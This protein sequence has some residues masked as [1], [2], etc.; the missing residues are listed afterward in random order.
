MHEQ[1]TSTSKEHKNWK[2]YDRVALGAEEGEITINVSNLVGNSSVLEMKNTKYNVQNAHY[3]ARE[4]VPQ[5]TLETLNND[6]WVRKFKNVF[7]KIDVQGYELSVIRKLASAEYNIIGF[8]IKLSLI[9]LYENQE[10]YLEIAGF[11]KSMGYHLCYAEP[12]SVRHN[13]M[14]QFNGLF[15]KEK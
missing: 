5:I 6:E 8:Y 13:K 15:L 3:V 4:V 2:V 10:D 14:V 7:I 12:E 1:L 11:L 9:T